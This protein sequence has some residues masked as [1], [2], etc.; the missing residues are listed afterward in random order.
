[1]QRISVVDPQAAKDLALRRGELLDRKLGDRKGAQECYRALLDEEE[2]GGPAEHRLREILRADSAWDELLA[3]DKRALE[4]TKAEDARIRLL[5][6]MA[7][8]Q[9]EQL[10]DPT[11]AAPLIHEVLQINPQHHR[12]LAAYEDFFRQKGDFRNLAELL[13]FSAKEAKDNGAPPMEVCAR[14]EELAEICEKRLGDLPEA[15]GAWEAIAKLHHD[16]R[17]SRDEI[18]RLTQKIEHVTDIARRLKYDITQAATPIEQR[19]A[20]R[21]M[22]EVYFRKNIDPLRTIEI[23]KEVLEEAPLDENALD[24]LIQLYEREANDDG[25]AWAL[26]Q[27][28]ASNVNLPQRIAILQRLADLYAG[29]LDSTK[30]ARQAYRDLAELL[31]Q[32]DDVHAARVK[33]FEQT[34]DYQGLAEELERRAKIAAGAD[35]RMAALRALGRLMDGLLAG[36]AQAVAAWKRV[37]EQDPNDEEALTALAD[38]YKR[39]GQPADRLAI[40]QRYLDRIPSSSSI[41]RIKVLRDIAHI[42]GHDLDQ[43]QF[44][45]TANQEIASILPADRD[46]LQALAKLYRRLNRYDDLVQILDQQIDLTDDPEDRATLAFLQVDILEEK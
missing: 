32:D 42:A 1:R 31:P 41:A 34:E 43:P 22:A 33:L 26:N 15:L 8:I 19:E 14:L 10:M 16:V 3:L 29:P 28:L 37:L 11:A 9:S 40:L 36:P 12:A 2:P 35:D 30:D 38:L 27:R 5:M 4:H 44:A 25:L 39:I 46:A 45:V 23:L 21:H 18:A 20:R 6:E 17:R 24:L 13:R 7:T